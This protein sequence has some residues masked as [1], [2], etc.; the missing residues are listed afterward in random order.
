MPNGLREVTLADI[1]RNNPSE[2]VEE[3]VVQEVIPEAKTEEVIEDAEPVELGEDPK[4]VDYDEDPKD[5][6]AQRDREA[7]EKRRARAEAKRLQQENEVLRG[8][9][10]ETPDEQYQRDVASG[11]ER[12]A[13]HKFLEDSFNRMTD[14]GRK[15]IKDFDQTMTQLVQVFEGWHGVPP[16][17]YEAIR[18]LSDGAEHKV[19][20]YLGKNTTVAEDIHETMQNSP[21]K[22]LAM[23]TKIVNKVTAPPPVSKVPPPIKPITGNTAR[24]T[25]PSDPNKM[26]EGDW[27]KMRNEQIRKKRE[28]RSM[29]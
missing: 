20:H 9:R 2:V 3:V 15:E 27:I 1:E 10:T 17:L 25:E 29:R 21:I 6:K 16:P 24:S 5:L 12:A 26:S 18:E 28:E 23:L 7:F 19:L 8:T 11:I 13:Q 14:A 4:E 22:G